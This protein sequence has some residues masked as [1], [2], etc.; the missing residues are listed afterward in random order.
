MKGGKG[1]KGAASGGL[2]TLIDTNRHLR[3]ITPAVQGPHWKEGRWQHTG[4]EAGGTTIHFFNVYGW[5]QGTNDLPSRQKA[6][7]LKLFEQV[8]SLGRAPWV[9]GGD[10]NIQPDQLWAQA[11]AP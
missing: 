7:W 8:A 9:I 6:L 11:L 2:A 3:R 4:V 5:P 1:I 10:W